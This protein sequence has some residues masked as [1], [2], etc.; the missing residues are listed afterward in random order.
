MTQIFQR[1]LNKSLEK[2][3]DR[4]ESTSG[5]DKSSN[6][7][8]NSTQ[9]VRSPSPNTDN[10]VQGYG[11]K[12]VSFNEETTPKRF[13]PKKIVCTYCRKF[14]HTENSCRKKRADNEKRQQQQDRQPLNE[15]GLT[16][17]L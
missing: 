13:S 9:R 11:K 14:N 2:V 7:H 10:T 12:R 4:R 16:Q 5:V 3:L 8:D 17:N 1:V 15:K 6:F